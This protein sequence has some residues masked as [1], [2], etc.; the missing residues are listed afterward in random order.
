MQEEKRNC[1]RVIKN[2]LGHRI[3][4]AKATNSIMITW[5]EAAR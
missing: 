5:L 1:E 3:R 4:R 2:R